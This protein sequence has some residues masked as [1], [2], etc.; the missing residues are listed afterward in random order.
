[1]YYHTY[2]CPDTLSPILTYSAEGPTTSV[3]T[4]TARFR[5]LEGPIATSKLNIEQNTLLPKKNEMLAK[6]F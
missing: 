1:M 3:T 4:T 6:S 5:T 2:P